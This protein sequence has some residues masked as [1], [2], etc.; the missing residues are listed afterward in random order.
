MNGLPPMPLEGALED[1]LEGP[2]PLG[3][4]DRELVAEAILRRLLAAYGH[5]VQAIA[6][7]GSCATGQDGPYSDIELWVML[8]DDLAASEARTVEWIWGAGKAEVNL[9][10]EAEL[11]SEAARIDA[12]WALTHGRFVHPV[13]LY[14]RSPGQ[15]D[16][17][18]RRALA[19]PAERLRQVM[20]ETVAGELYESLG[21]LRNAVAMG[22]TGEGA[23]LFLKLV[24][25]AS[26]LT[27]LAQSHAFH[28]T[29]TLLEEA[30]GLT[31]PAGFTDLIMIARRG[32]LA[33]ATRLLGTAEDYW[34]GLGKWIEA[35]NLDLTPFR[36]A[37]F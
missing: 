33:D 27:A 25:T 32:A 7:Y 21:R 17:I 5:R 28:S 16:D 22:R 8:D 24:E 10:G 9:A 11:L 19:L 34:S 26:A 4:A 35:L 37:D 18:R 6:L 14:E 13:M 15:V 36:G 1:I 31:G 12:R 30:A 20:A 2:S 3:R 29:S 23:R